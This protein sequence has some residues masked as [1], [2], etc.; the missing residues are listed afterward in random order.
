MNN[1][2]IIN[3]TFKE[4]DLQLRDASVAQV[5]GF[6]PPNK[7]CASYWGGRVYGLPGEEWPKRNGVELSALLQ[8]NVKELPFVPASLK[9][10]ELFTV[11]VYEENF[12]Y[13]I[14]NGEGWCIRTYN[15]TKELI[16]LPEPTYQSEIKPFPIRWQ[17]I[18]NDAPD[19]T[20]AL[21]IVNETKFLDIPNNLEIFSQKY[22]TS[23]GTKIGGWPFYLQDND[24]ELGDFVFQIDSE[25]KTNWMWGDAGIAYFFKNEQGDWLMD[26][27]S[28]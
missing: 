6:Q 17:L 21:N 16:L 26:W 15:S 8:V 12:S 19:W 4:L 25:Y 22:Q 23:T 11:F 28:L 5:G 2:E 18:H 13:G 10:I 3:L 7:K 1:Q 27:D 24:K 9:G 14:S 20:L